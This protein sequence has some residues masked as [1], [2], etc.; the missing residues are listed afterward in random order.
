[1][2]TIY[3]LYFVFHYMLVIVEILSVIFLIIDNHIL[4]HESPCYYVAL[5][6][7]VSLVLDVVSRQHV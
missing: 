7:C 6:L 3:L 5:L 1:M 4:G 2:Y